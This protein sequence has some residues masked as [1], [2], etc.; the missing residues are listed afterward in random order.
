[1]KRAVAAFLPLGLWAVAVLLVGSLQIE[2]TPL[3]SGSDKAAHFV[4]YGIG[5]VLAAWAG[6][7]QGSARAAWIALLLVILVGAADELNQTTVPGR[8]GDVMDWVADATGAL[9]A[10]LVADRLLKRD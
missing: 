7:K 9:F 5:G 10:F 4:M 6:R 3:P 2:S 1:M 8:H